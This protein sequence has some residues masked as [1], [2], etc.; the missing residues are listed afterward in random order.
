MSFKN[1]RKSRSSPKKS[2]SKKKIIY[3][4]GE[5]VA[6]V[7]EEAPDYVYLYKIKEDVYSLE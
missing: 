5:I 4:A 3:P 1:K 2:R 7:G 6:I